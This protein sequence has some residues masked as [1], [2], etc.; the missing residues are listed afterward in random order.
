MA[1]TPKNRPHRGFE[2]R[3]SRLAVL[4][5]NLTA[6]MAGFLS[7]T[8]DKLEELKCEKVTQKIQRMFENENAESSSENFA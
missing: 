4:H 1:A 7:L 8:I 5:L 6:T 2:P 3:P